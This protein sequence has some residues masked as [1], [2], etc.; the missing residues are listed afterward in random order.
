M[1]H[2]LIRNAA[3]AGQNS[4]IGQKSA[5]SQFWKHCTNILLILTEL[6]GVFQPVLI[7]FS[8]IK[9]VQHAARQNI[10]EHLFQSPGVDGSAMRRKTGLEA[11]RHFPLIYPA[12]GTLQHLLAAA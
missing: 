9:T 1:L 7:N 8:K 6:N 5:K 2:R 10:K 4:S 11:K 12:G 3:L